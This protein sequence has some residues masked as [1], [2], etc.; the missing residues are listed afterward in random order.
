MTSSWTFRN[1]RSANR[2]RFPG[3]N[4]SIKETPAPASDSLWVAGEFLAG[5]DVRVPGDA[6]L[7]TMAAHHPARSRRG[8]AMCKPQKRRSSAANASATTTP[9]TATPRRP[10]CR[11]RIKMLQ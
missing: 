2:T 7:L 9:T 3:L 11:P 4:D 6:F 1:T 8:C 10:L 5:L